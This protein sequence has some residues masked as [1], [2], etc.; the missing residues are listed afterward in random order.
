MNLL[1]G[2]S[3]K[4]KKIKHDIGK[5][6][7]V[8]MAGQT[9][10]GKSNL[11][12]SF[13]CSLIKRLGPEELNLFLI[14]CKKVE[15]IFY[16]ELSHL[17]CPVTFCN[18]SGISKFEKMEKEINRRKQE[19]IKKPFILV[20]I[21]EFSDLVCQYPVQLERLV[22]MIA[23]DGSRVGVGLLLYT[24]RPAK[25]VITQKI[26]KLIE[27]RIGFKTASDID[28][29]TIIHKRGCTELLGNGD[30]MYLKY[31]DS[32]PLHFQAPLITEEEIKEIIGK[33]YSHFVK[34]SSSV[35]TTEDKSRDKPKPSKNLISE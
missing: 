3:E 26:D 35:K 16:K 32:K 27:T 2:T 6:P 28:S 25:D 1:I 19:N 29:Q 8:L 20:V 24:S 21:D 7:L 10:S 4:G 23:A 9:G 12:H 31:L 34:T 15:F 18:K 22:E 17:F 13:I 33:I 30:G 5:Q 14:D 11:A